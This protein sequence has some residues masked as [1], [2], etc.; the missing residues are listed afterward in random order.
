MSAF[1]LALADL[2]LLLHFAVVL[3]NVFGL[4]AIP[5]GAWRGWPFVRVFWWRA[6]HLATL[7]L[8]ALQAAAGRLCFLTIWHAALVQ[9]AGSRSS[10]APGIADF[11]S[12][13]I[14]WPLPLWAF[15]VIYVAVALFTLALWR[16][17]P[18]RYPWKYAP[19]K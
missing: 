7:A 12:R 13:L 19:V 9:M 8:V 6:L 4:I 3:F 5:L 10:L 18:P 11:I 2:V 14:F 16:L 1:Y 15:I 17:V